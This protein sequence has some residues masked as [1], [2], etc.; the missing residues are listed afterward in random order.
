MSLSSLTVETP[1]ALAQDG[2][3]VTIF[4]GGQWAWQPGSDAVAG[5]LC[6]REGQS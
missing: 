4:L 5:Q 3:A 2:A 1:S 6:R